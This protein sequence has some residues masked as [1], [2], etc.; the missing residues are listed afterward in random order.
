[1]AQVNS[2][3]MVL[4]YHMIADWFDA[5]RSREL[6]EKPYLDQVI[7]QLNDG[8]I[9]LDLGSGMGEPIAGYFI[10]QGI[11]IVGVD[12]SQRLVGLA[13]ERFPNTRF[14]L[15]DMRKLHLHEDFDAIIVWHS[16]FHL[17]PSEQRLMFET[18]AEHMKPGGILLFTSGHKEGEVWSDNGGVMLYH[19]SLSHDEYT[20]LLNQHGFEL[21]SLNV[22]DKNCGGA[23][24]WMAK[25]KTEN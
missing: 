16:L 5:H 24:V 6:F 3:D 4:A 11:K 15:K 13:E 1:M 19:S 10:N 7:N 23:T 2:K 21:F 20:R 22:E 12:S 9:V 17:S 8:A 25:Y 18:F 14:L